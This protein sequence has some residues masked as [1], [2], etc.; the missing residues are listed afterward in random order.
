MSLEDAKLIMDS[1]DRDRVKRTVYSSETRLAYHQ[2]QLLYNLINEVRLL[3]EDI[4]RL[5][6][7]Q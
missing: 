5:G 2:A 4:K 1:I 6:V 3:R 7:K